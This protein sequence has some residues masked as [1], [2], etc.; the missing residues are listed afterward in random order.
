MPEFSPTPSQREAI[1]KRGCP[2]LVSAGAGSGKTRVLTERLMAYLTDP[3]KPADIDS[4][5]IIT[6]TRAAAAELR[7]RITEEL[8]R[9]LERDPGNLRLRRQSALI[10]RAQIST[11]HSFCANLLRENCQA[12]GLSPDFRIIDDERADAMRAACLDRVLE[13]RYEKL[14]EDPDFHLL[15]DTVG[16]GRDDSA[17]AELVLDL[18]EKMQC[19]PFPRAWAAEQTALLAEPH[20]DAGE[21]VWGRELLDW[22]KSVADYWSGEMDRLLLEMRADASARAAYEDHFAAIGDELRE[23]SRCFALGWDRA[24]DA[25]PLHV[26][27]LPRIK[28]PYDEALVQRLKSRREKC[29]KIFSDMKEKTFAASSAELLEDMAK[30]APAM[31]ALLALTIDFDEAYRKDKQS[32]GL[33]DY[34]DLEHRAAALLT[35]AAGRPTELASRLSRRFT[36]VMVDEYQDVSLVQDAIFGAVSDGGRRLFLVGDVKQSI[37]R[38]RLADP[39]IFQGKYERYGRA[40]SGAARILLRENFRSRREVID[41]VNAVFSQSMSKALGDVEY[42]DEAALVCGAAWYEGEVPK[43]EFLLCSLPE[44]TGEDSPDKLALEAAFTA[45][46]IRTLVASGARVTTPSGTRPMEYGD[47][48]ILLRSPGKTGGVYREALMA[49]GVPVGQAQ[50]SGFFTA[51]EISLVLSMLAVMDNP[52]K[53]IPLIAVLRSAAFGFTPD[54]LSLIRAADRNADFFSALQ[55]AGEENEKCRAF[56]ET[57]SQLRSEAVDLSAAE[58]VW[59]VIERLQLL[60]LCSAMDDG[61]R[62]RA[63]LM[64]LV[65]L[66]RD[67]EATGYRGLHRFALWLQA[68]AEKGKEANIGSDAVSAVQIVSIHHSKGLEYPVVFLCNAGRE[69]NQTDTRQTVLVHPTLGL[70]PRVVDLEKRIRYPSLARL[71]IAK[72]QER[73]NLSEEMRLLYVALTRARERLY[74]VAMCKSAEKE[75]EKAA[76]IAVPPISAEALRGCRSF[77]SWLLP[78]CLADGGA[79]FTLRLCQTEDEAAPGEVEIPAVP[80]DEEA[81]KELRRRLAFRYTHEQAVELPSKVTA[82]E[83]KG[84]FERDADAEELLRPKAYSFRMPVLGSGERA[85]TAAERGVATHLVLQY[86]DFAKATSRAGIKA[87]IERLCAARFLSR[88][89]ADAVNVSAIERLFRSELGGRMLRAK[90]PLREFRF[91]LL[92]DAKRLY[93]EVAGEELLLQGV[94]DCCLEE[95]GELVIIDYKTDSVRTEAEIA[96]RAELYRGQLAAYAESLT[97]IFGKRVKEG[98]LFFLTPGRTVRLF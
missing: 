98:V 18:H 65:E 17:L 48:A 66:S 63:N 94:V 52:H 54:E 67:F 19:H 38:F 45:R 60:A 87:E 6:Y 62:R 4:F 91:S 95:D 82:T 51:L 46:Q 93:P 74:V 10:R 42:N 61:A 34:S 85:L 3:E 35:D 78:V 92:L 26:P 75:L 5:L 71:A 47:I 44:K 64:A 40:D 24:A 39:E 72:R 7:G 28:K 73:E 59:L 41:G 69:F 25:L 21:T 81:A 53:D 56:L 57:L 84:R 90:E 8:A 55:K 36:E 1:E 97:R 80:V 43:P 68:L 16:E 37:Y 77:A 27:T 89:E 96:A 88:R 33:V 32:R 58:T 23:L 11:I 9:R 86:M 70:G 15:A 31:Q 49:A 79:H 50:G 12:A 2:I 83:L 76:A 29:K 22:A 30:T 13:A 20:A 14:D